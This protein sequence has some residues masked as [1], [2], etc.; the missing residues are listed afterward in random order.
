MFIGNSETID[1]FGEPEDCSFY[2]G[3]RL[4]TF[5]V[6]K[7]FKYRRNDVRKTWWTDIVLLV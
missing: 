3:R 2:L 4:L 7:E 6:I 1:D 5:G